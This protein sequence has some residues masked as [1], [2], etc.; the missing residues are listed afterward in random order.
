MPVRIV[1]RTG[2]IIDPPVRTSSDVA[3]LRELDVQ[4]L[5]PI[6]R[7]RDDLVAELGAIP[8]IGFAGAPFT[9]ASYLIEGGPSRDHLRLAAHNR[10]SPR[11]G[12]GVRVLFPARR[13]SLLNPVEALRAE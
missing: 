10:G 8:L 6:V 9:L 5:A 2:P 3:A 13:A 1:A 7:R 11:D 12:C 4:A